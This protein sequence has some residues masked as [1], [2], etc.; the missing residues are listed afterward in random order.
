MGGN[1]DENLQRWNRA[2]LGLTLLGIAVSLFTIVKAFLQPDMQ[3]AFYTTSGIQTYSEQD[4]TSSQRAILISISALPQLCWLWCMW[5]IVRLSRH[6]SRGEVLSIGLVDC[7]ERFGKGMFVL[8]ITEAWYFPV[9]F[10]YLR[11]LKTFDPIKDFWENVLSSGALTSWM[12]AVLVV[13]IARILRIGVRIRE[14]AELT[15]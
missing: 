4:F 12:A 11:T 3:L 5:Q 13:V 8:G 10:A 2:L 7:I 6:F 15:I 14:D 1:D 9:V